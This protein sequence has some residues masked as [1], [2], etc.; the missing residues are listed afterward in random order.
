MRVA[1]LIKPNNIQVVNEAFSAL[2]GPGQA[3]V[4][5]MAVGICGTDMHIFQGKRDDVA[6]PRVMGHELSGTVQEVGTDVDSVKVGDRVVL[7]PVISCGE[8]KPCRQGQPNVC[9]DVKCYGVQTDGG[10]RDYIVV[11]AKKLYRF[12]DRYSYPEASLAEPFSIAAN[13]LDRANLQKGDSVVIIGAGTVGLCTAQAAKGLG[14]KVLISDRVEKKLEMAKLINCDRVVNADHEN[15]KD[16][17]AAF[18]PDGVDVIIDC[19]GNAAM[20]KQ[21]VELATP[22]TRIVIIGFDGYEAS[23]S[24]A[25]ITKRELTI[26]GSRMN[27]LKFPEIVRWLDA[28]II[29]PSLLITAQFPIGQIQQAFEYSL[30]HPENIKTVIVFQSDAN[31]AR[32]EPHGERKGRLS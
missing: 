15:L 30:S 4:K 9:K 32:Q 7:D 11:D 1:K 14:A 29:H 21:A 13:I 31:S 17:V 12:P 24:P 25:D 19:V 10:F 3:V 23:I 27:A 8:C 22:L 5:V 18:F 2:P 26:V 20:L 28:D 6:M 16:A